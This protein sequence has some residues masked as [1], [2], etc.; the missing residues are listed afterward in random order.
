MTLPP[1]SIVLSGQGS[2]KYQGVI[3]FLNIAEVIK[4]SQR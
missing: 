3:R 4:D 2:D 1:D